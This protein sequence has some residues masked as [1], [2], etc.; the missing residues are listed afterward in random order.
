MISRFPR[1]KNPIID[2]FLPSPQQQ[3]LC[4]A[5]EGQGAGAEPG[6][7]KWDN[8]EKGPKNDGRA[9][10]LQANSPKNMMKVSPRIDRRY[11]GGDSAGFAE[12]GSAR[13]LL[14]EAPG[15]RGVAHTRR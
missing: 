12:G 4:R 1:Y 7:G 14:G 2:P 15:T 9:A 11:G 8:M 5:G 6:C 10:H 13:N 3:E